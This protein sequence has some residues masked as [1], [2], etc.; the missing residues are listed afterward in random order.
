LPS[1]ASRTVDLPAELQGTTPSATIVGDVNGDGRTDLVLTTR[2][3]HGL[4]LGSADGIPTK[5]VTVFHLPS[6]GTPAA[7][8][9]SGQG[10]AG[11]LGLGDIDGDG[12]DDLLLVGRW[13]PKCADCD[14]DHD[15]AGP[16]NAWIVR[17]TAGGIDPSP[18]HMLTGSSDSYLSKLGAGRGDVDGDGIDD[19][20]YANGRHIDLYLGARDGIGAEP[21]TRTVDP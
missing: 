19:V 18:P 3:G 20:M 7:K 1:A 17:G 10:I 15:A 11:V 12:F 14:F 6:G 21:K 9:G 13:F 16:T 8:D 5:S 2:T 4:F